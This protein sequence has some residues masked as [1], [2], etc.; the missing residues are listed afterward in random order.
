MVDRETPHFRRSGREHASAVRIFLESE[1]ALGPTRRLKG[2]AMA[3]RLERSL[4]V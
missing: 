1:L 4:G 2:R 3:P